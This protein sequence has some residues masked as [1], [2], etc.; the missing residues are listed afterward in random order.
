M[1]HPAILSDTARGVTTPAFRLRDLAVRY[2]DRPALQGITLD[3]PAR[4]ITAIVGPSGA[5]KSTLLSV[6]NRMIDLAPSARVT[7][8]ITFAGQ[9]IGGPGC[10]L[11]ALRRQVGL[12]F[13][14]PNPFPLSIRENIVL[15]LR[16]HGLRERHAQ[17]RIVARV[18]AETGLLDEVCDRLAAPA[19]TLSGG[20][21]QR[22]C[23]ARALALEPEVL[24]L[25]EPC[26]ALDPLATATIEELIRG[27]TK[28]MTVIIVTHNLAQARR[29][30][31]NVA[32]LWRRN[33]AGEVIEYG[34]T[35][36]IFDRPADPLTRAYVNG[37]C[38]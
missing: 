23:L 27:L 31:S 3:L 34:P 20:Q 26:S 32:V 16:E 6:L 19:F 30:A 25:D 17:D 4:Q 29:L 14:R 35:G 36:Q 21:Q 7:G 13:Q 15:A 10:D 24:L 2:G 11:G 37:L 5:G 28:T 12:I 1:N 33:G 22:L 18:L 8:Q 9:D 38:G